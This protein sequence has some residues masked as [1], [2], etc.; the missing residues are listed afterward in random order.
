MTK[1]KTCEELVEKELQ[2]EIRD[3]RASWEAT[4]DPSK[5]TDD[6]QP[7]REYGYG[8]DWVE[9]NT[10]ENQKSGYWRWTTSGG[11]PSSE[12]RFFLD[13]KS[14]RHGKLAT[15]YYRYMDWFDGAGRTLCGQDLAL[16]AEVWAGYLSELR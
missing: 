7:I 1:E 14:Y 9:P 12:F 3:I 16:L 2:N 6:I 4:I 5:V 13:S 11:G 8:F 10:F 15:V